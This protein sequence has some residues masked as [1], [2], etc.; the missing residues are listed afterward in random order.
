MN[1]HYTNLQLVSTHTLLIATST[2]DYGEG[3]IVLFN[4]VTY[5]KSVP[6]KLKI[7]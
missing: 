2:S 4:S 7:N 3:T 5:I 1:G 6:S